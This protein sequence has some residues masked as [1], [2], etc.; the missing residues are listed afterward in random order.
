MS[1]QEA[2]DIQLLEP[3]K[4]IMHLAPYTLSYWRQVRLCLWRDLQRLR[5]DP[6]ITLAMLFGNFFEALIIA[7][8]FYNLPQNTSSFFSRG[9][10][11]FMMVL[12]NAF[13][14]LIEI[15]GLYAKRAIVEKHNRYALY[16]PSAEALASILVDMPYKVTNAI[17]VNSTLYFMAN[18]RREAGAYFFF[19]LVS[20]MLTLSMSMFFRLFASL[21]KTLAQ[22]LAPACI[23]LLGMTLYTGFAIPVSYMRGWAKWLRFIVSNV[24]YDCSRCFRS[25][26]T[27]EPGLLWLRKCDAQRIS[28]SGIP[29]LPIYPF[30]SRVR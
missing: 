14:S 16:H 10:V 13:G 4:L 24:K 30:W 8:V 12:L 17:L 25:N 20:F 1:L 15:I 23:V 28:W 5:T 26:M 27:T 18:L 3:E 22:A 7:S 29:M 21:T 9:A 2:T 11:L 6:S 19:L